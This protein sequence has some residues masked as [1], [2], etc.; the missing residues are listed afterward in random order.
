MLLLAK[1]NLNAPETRALGLAQLERLLIVAPS[2]HPEITHEVLTTY[3]LAAM[4]GREFEQALNLF[5][6]LL[7]ASPSLSSQALASSLIGSA[8]HA[9]LDKRKA[10]QAFLASRSLADSANNEELS[11]LSA[12]NAGI[13]LL[14]I[15]EPAE[16]DKI[17]NELKTPDSRAD[18]LLERGLRLSD[19]N[20]SSARDL[21]DQFLSEFP[22]HPRC[23]EAALSLAES[24]LFS[25]PRER[26]LAKDYLGTLKFDLDNQ[27]NLEIRRILAFLQLVEKKDDTYKGMDLASEFLKKLP[28]HVLAPRIA[29]QQ[30]QAY[31]RADDHGPA[32]KSFEALLSSYPDDPLTEVARLQSA[33]SGLATAT[34][35]SKTRA[36][37]R[38]DEL[39][40]NKGVLATEAAIRKARFL[41]DQGEQTNALDEIKK[42]LEPKNLADNYRW[43]SL[44][45][46]G[47]AYYQLNDDENALKAY[48]NLL[49]LKKISIATRNHASYLKGRSLKNLDRLDEAFE[50]FYAVVNRQIDTEKMS[51]LEWKWFDECGKGALRILEEKKQ[52]NA[53]IKL[54]EKIS[55]SGSPFAPDAAERAKHLRLEH[56]IWD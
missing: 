26:L 12:L 18:L 44:V 48:N 9:L 23:D 7:E 53:A 55:R 10:S 20:D 52:W 41:I 54:A 31:Q 38:L 36:R 51:E 15:A 28:D 29:F 39:I 45:L 14:S 5:A 33:I 16:L 32:W 47:E 43:R 34:T 37:E 24:Y 56:F 49:A 35:P 25:Q 17:T 46:R 11:R 6:R 30:G 22:E 27:A 40:E 8:A 42:I 19:I 3:G 50:T 1:Q 4:A 13:S 21:L 2:S